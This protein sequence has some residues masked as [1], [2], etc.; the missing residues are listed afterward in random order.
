[1][2]GPNWVPIKI[3][4]NVSAVAFVLGLAI[5]LVR[6]LTVPEQAG[7]SSYF[8]WFFLLIICGTGATG[9][10]TELVRWAGAVTGAYIL[11]A[12]HLMFILA[13]FLYLPFSKFAHLG[14]RTLAIAWGKSVGRNMSLAPL[15]NY[16]PPASAET[17]E[18]MTEPPA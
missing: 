17:S 15:P 14:Y 13:L 8:D 9:L 3:L 6:R 7:N 12:I 2:Y 11:Y 16:E 4:G 5:M 10:L 1:M 18:S